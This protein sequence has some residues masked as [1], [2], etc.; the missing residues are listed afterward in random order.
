MKKLLVLLVMVLF[1]TMSYAQWSPGPGNLYMTSYG[2]VGIG[3]T[4]PTA[5]IQVTEPTSIAAFV[6]NSNQTITA[7][8]GSTN[9]GQYDM[10]WNGTT[11]AF[12][13]NVLRR[14][15]ATAHVEMLQTLHNNAGGT[16]NFL[17]VD[18][19]NGKFQMQG[20]ITD[21]EFDNG[22]N[23]LFNNAGTI[24]I[25]MGGL[26]VPPLAKVA[27][28]GKVVCKEIEVT[29]TGLPP[30]YVFEPSYKLRSLYDV[31]SFVNTNK[32]LPDVPSGKEISKGLNLGDMNA[33]LLQKVEEL[34]LYM[35]N[36]QKEN[37]ALKARITNLEK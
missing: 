18:L 27:I 3:V 22:G 30:D 14:N 2:K 8:T 10:R 32:H 4:A 9:I 15:N 6:L 24:S 29:L 23:I 19:D 21:A 16:L 12:Y 36:L 31:E 35:I 7:T 11:G 17:Y 28:G 25:G 20:G 13:R 5:S 34:T 33:T 26:P 1:G 37:D